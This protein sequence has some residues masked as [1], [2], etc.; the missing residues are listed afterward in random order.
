M[1]NNL[2][3]A[4][5]AALINTLMSLV[6]TC[7]MK[8]SDVKLL[9]MIRIEFKENKENL[10]RSALTTGIVVYATLMFVRNTDKS[11]INNLMNMMN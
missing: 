1:D 5:V 4:I 3:I 7:L 11:Q 8:K 6:I 9:E 10:M 2:Y